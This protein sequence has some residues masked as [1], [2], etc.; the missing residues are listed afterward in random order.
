M[1]VPITIATRDNTIL[2]PV[3]YKFKPRFMTNSALLVLHAL[4]F[5]PKAD[6]KSEHRH[7][8]RWTFWRREQMQQTTYVEVY[9]MTSSAAAC[10]ASWNLIGS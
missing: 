3:G 1:I 10:N 5:A 9:S 8:L 4:R 7:L 2:K 6:A